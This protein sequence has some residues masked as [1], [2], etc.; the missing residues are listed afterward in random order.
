MN[1]WEFKLGLTA[2]LVAM[3]A[4]LVFSHLPDELHRRKI[5]VAWFCMSA[6]ATWFLVFLWCIWNPPPWLPLRR[7]HSPGPGFI[8]TGSVDIQ[9]DNWAWAIDYA[10]H[11][12]TNT[13]P[14]NTPGPPTYHFNL[15]PAGVPS[16]P[17]EQWSH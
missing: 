6:H 10:R 12:A 1:Y 8:D 15:V 3:V 7:S 16:P 5:A 4:W 11:H 14:I 9:I 17:L 2:W 13:T